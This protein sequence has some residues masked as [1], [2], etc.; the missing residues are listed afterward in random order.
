MEQRQRSAA[1]TL[2]EAGYK[3]PNL[4]AAGGQGPSYGAG[5]VAASESNRA[6][7]IGQSG[8]APSAQR[9]T[10]STSTFSIFLSLNSLPFTSFSV[11]ITRHVGPFLPLTIQYCPRVT[12]PMAAPSIPTQCSFLLSLSG[13]SDSLLG[14]SSWDTSSRKM[15]AF[16]SFHR[17]TSMCSP[18]T[19]RYQF[20]KQIPHRQVLSKV[21]SLLSSGL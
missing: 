18:N 14:P 9:A 7:R 11:G 8:V 5:R 16:L 20:L 21:F 12:L 2:D 13:N 15:N 10:I 3:G 6:S 17:A 4:K 1:R 19:K